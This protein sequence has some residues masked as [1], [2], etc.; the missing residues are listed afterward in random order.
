[1]ANRRRKILDFDLGLIEEFFRAFTVQGRMNLHIAQLS[2]REPHHAYEAM[3]K[4]VAR[5]V[6]TA[7][8]IDRRVKGVPSTKGRMK[9]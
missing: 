5:A 2:G 3:F 9:A 7:V 1:V 6:G 8:T 4:S